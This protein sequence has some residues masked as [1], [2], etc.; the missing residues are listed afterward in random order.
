MKPF[1][2]DGL[3][4]SGRN[5]ESLVALCDRFNKPKARLNTSKRTELLVVIRKMRA[6]CEYLELPVSLQACDELITLLENEE[7]SVT[8]GDVHSLFKELSKRI[9][10]ELKAHMFFCVSKEASNL[11][12]KPLDQWGD[13]IA[14]FPSVR[15]DVEEAS[16]SLAL[17]RNTAAVFHLMRV[18]G[19]GITALGKSLN[20]ATL[21]AFSN[22][23]WGNVLRRCARELEKESKNMSPLWRSNKQFYA[24]ATSKLYAVKDAW[25][26]PNAHEIGGKYTDEEALDVYRA[27]R[28]LMRQL[29]TK[30]KE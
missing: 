29:S 24:A 14:A 4:A 21:D 1:N 7:R 30:L 19:G 5:I 27:T 3:F 20:E 17:R 9:Q 18:L 13:T 28:S 2:A 26:N 25:R 23:T 22:V 8:L 11:Y 6:G 15:F 16:K 12:Q 10:V